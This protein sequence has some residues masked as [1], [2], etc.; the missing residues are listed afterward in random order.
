M[1][2]FYLREEQRCKNKHAA[3]AKQTLVLKQYSLTPEDS[4]Y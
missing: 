1:R 3:K 4:N 2:H